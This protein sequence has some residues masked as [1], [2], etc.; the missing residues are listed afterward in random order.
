MSPGYPTP[1]IISLIKKSP[2]D[3]ALNL[4]K[5]SIL[6][7]SQNGSPFASFSL[8]PFKSSVPLPKK[9]RPQRFSALINLYVLLIVLIKV[10]GYLFF[11]RVRRSGK[12]LNRLVIF[13]YHLV[14]W[15]LMIF[16]LPFLRSCWMIQVRFPL[17]HSKI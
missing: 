5:Q 8:I 14:R 4:P 13:G 2:N 15:N 7:L 1:E 11:Y 12:S 3:P 10:N 16:R 9:P 17:S 6:F